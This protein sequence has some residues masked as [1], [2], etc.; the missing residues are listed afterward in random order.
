MNTGPCNQRCLLQPCFL[1]RQRADQCRST[2]RT[3]SHLVWYTCLK[4]S[5]TSLAGLTMLFRKSKLTVHL[6]S[7]P[8][9]H[10]RCSMYEAIVLALVSAILCFSFHSLPPQLEFRHTQAGMTKCNGEEAETE[11]IHEANLLNSSWGAN[12]ATG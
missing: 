1:L 8:D 10:S 6:I 9:F 2:C 12:N 5:L 4:S 7:S 11:A 3:A